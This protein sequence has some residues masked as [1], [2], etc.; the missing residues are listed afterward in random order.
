MAEDYAALTDYRMMQY[1]QLFDHKNR[2]DAW[3]ETA[4]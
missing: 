4:S 3:Y 2:N 1:A